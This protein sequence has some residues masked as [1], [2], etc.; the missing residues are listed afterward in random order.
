MKALTLSPERRREVR[1]DQKLMLILGPE[2]SQ[3]SCPDFASELSA[4][5]KTGPF[6]RAAR[7]LPQL[8]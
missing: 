5:V 8:W 1:A 6:N 2:S 3:E 7:Q 4:A